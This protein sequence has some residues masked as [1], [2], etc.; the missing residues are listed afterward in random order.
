MVTIYTTIWILL[1]SFNG[2]HI[3]V[4]TFNTKAECIKEYNKRNSLGKENKAC[5]ELKAYIPHRWE[6]NSNDF[7]VNE[8]S[9]A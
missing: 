8:S 4:D 6:W 9:K 1:A 3:P 7:G 2:E 5:V